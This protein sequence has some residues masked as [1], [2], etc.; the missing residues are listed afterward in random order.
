MT[1]YFGY[2]ETLKDENTSYLYMEIYKKDIERYITIGIGFKGKK[3]QGVTS[4]GFIIKDGR[5]IGKDIFL[6]KQQNGKIPLTKKELKNLIGNG[7]EIYENQK[8]YMEA[9]NQNIFGFPSV[10]EYEEY[11]KLLIEIR[12][13]KLSTGKDMSPTI[14]TE[15]LKKSLGSLTDE[16]LL[17]VAESL[18]NMNKTKEYIENLQRSGKAVDNIIKTYKEYNEY[19]IYQKAKN[20]KHSTVRLNHLK[21]TIEKETKNK[22]RNEKQ[23][24]DMQNKLDKFEEEIKTNK[25]EIENLKKDERFNLEEELI[26]IKQELIKQEKEEQIKQE[27][28]ELIRSKRF[29]K[30]QEL[31]K[32]NSEYQEF[33]EELEAIE[34]ETLNMSGEI[35]YAEFE[36]IMKE[37]KENINKQYNFFNM[38]EHIKIYL[39]RVK[40]TKEKLEILTKLQN[41]YTKLQLEVD[42]FNNEISNLNKTEEKLKHNLNEEKNTYVDNFFKWEQ[43][44]KYLKIENHEKA[45]ITNKIE[46][47]GIKSIYDD[48]LTSLRVPYNRI[49]KDLNLKIYNEENKKQESNKKIQELKQE[50]EAWK[51][52][53]EPEPLREKHII[54]NRKKLDKYNISYI[55]L[56]NAIEFKKEIEENEKNKIEAALLDMGILDAL[57]ISPND[58]EKIKEID[59]GFVDKYLSESTMEF[60]YSICDM[61]DVVKPQDC[62]VKVEDISNVLTHIKLD[63]QDDKTYV[64]KEGEYKIGLLNGQAHKNIKAKYIGKEAKRQY[65]EKQ[66][67]LLKKEIED[68]LETIEIYNLNIEEIKELLKSLD[69]EFKSFPSIENLENINKEI[70]QTSNLIGSVVKQLNNKKEQTDKALV[71]LMQEKQAVKEEMSKLDFPQNLQT[72]QELEENILEFKDL[73]LELE[74]VSTKI[75]HKAEIKVKLEQEIEDISDQFDNLNEEVIFLVKE[76]KV[77]K[78]KIKSSQNI[79]DTEFEEKKKMLEE[80]LIKEESLPK[81]K[82]AILINKTKTETENQR[83]AEDLIKENETLEITEKENGLYKEI[84]EEELNLKYVYEVDMELEELMTNLNK[85]ENEKRR[86]SYYSDNLTIA[87]KENQEYLVEYSLELDT[88]LNNE[89]KETNHILNNALQT[90]ARRDIMCVLDLKR[91]NLLKL[92]GNIETN[93]YQLNLTIEGEDRILF[94]EILT[95]TIGRKIMDKINYAKRWIKDMNELMEN[96]KTSSDLSFSLKW[97]PKV[98][99]DEIE[100]DTVELVEILSSDYRLLKDEDRIKA[101]KHFRQKFEKATLKYKDKDNIVSFYNIMKETLDYRN[102][103]DFEYNHKKGSNVK[104]VLTNTAFQKLSGGERA[105]AMYVPLFAAV[106]AKYESAKPDAMR[107]ISIDEA[108]AGVDDNNIR[109]MFKILTK[110]DLNYIIN[111][112]VL[113]GEYDTIPTLAINELIT[114]PKKHIVSVVRYKWNGKIKELVVK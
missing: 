89:I 113:W 75:V 110:L 56:Y 51:N 12:M 57:I 45:E 103:F 22:Q 105:M 101:S 2:D 19:V 24:I 99:S 42:E 84:Y 46:D 47:Y 78:E 69:I 41:E 71:I 26:R 33:I 102:W 70:D 10:E 14:V 8:Q 36:Y 27:R 4:Y 73:I 83:I 18:E 90:R 38:N 92:K 50:L 58:I 35:K 86:L 91:V 82:E 61:F 9:V 65:K 107:L 39:T 63:K 29:S 59:E 30:D 17:P 112:Q 37:I 109:D 16:E 1:M 74:K 100:M 40:K 5:R 21:Q 48:I 68:I 11:I 93:L 67:E 94:E 114:D 88:I 31:K 15:I 77:N 28:L 76:I 7:G 60:G 64:G 96:L 87:Y 72:Y 106:Y 104:R 79:M 108:F 13:S 85:Y 20:F 53:K 62:N 3:N 97:Q 25:F 55:P 49:E 66:I 23:I 52:E 111:S 34:V 98:A 81:E 95:N 32:V 80:C 54:E 6:Y 43:E 44:N